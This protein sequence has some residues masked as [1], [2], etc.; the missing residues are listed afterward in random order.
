MNQIKEKVNPITLRSKKW[1][2][3][4]LIELMNEKPYSEITIKEIAERAD[5][6]RQTVYRNFKTKEAILEYYVDEFYIDF[7]KILSIKSHI[8]YD[9]LLLTYFEYWYEKK[10]FVKKLIDNNVYSILLDLHLK[11]LNSM[12]SNPKFKHLILTPI[13]NNDNYIN[14]FSAGGLWFSL[15]KWIEDDTKKTPLEM[16]N[17]VLNFYRIKQVNAQKF[18]KDI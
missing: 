14:H 7:I 9:N 6:V 4:S 18:N 16:T 12:G 2:V 10:D 5:L 15:K 8:S 17:I 11:Y 13:S 3:N 1:I